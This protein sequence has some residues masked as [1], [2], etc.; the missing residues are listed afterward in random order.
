[1]KGPT[2]NHY[3]RRSQMLVDGRQRP[4]D[5]TSCILK[6]C[7]GAHSASNTLLGCMR[8]VSGGRQQHWSAPTASCNTMVPRKPWRQPEMDTILGLVTESTSVPA[9]AVGCRI[10]DPG[11]HGYRWWQTAGFS[12]SVRTVRA[13]RT[14]RPPTHATHP[15]SLSAF[16][17]R[18]EQG[19]REGP[20]PKSLCTTKKV[21]KWLQR[22]TPNWTFPLRSFLFP[23]GPGAGVALLQQPCNLCCIWVP[24]WSPIWQLSHGSITLAVWELPHHGRVN[25][26]HHCCCIS[27]LKL[28]KSQPL[29]TPAV[30]GL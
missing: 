30:W 8:G 25:G 15:F 27:S 23:G 4:L 21:R 2:A 9:G 11:T 7:T 5:D 28:E 22:Y 6:R 3:G 26:L 20:R 29:L 19:R 17:E 1:M 12:H 14:V 18:G 13:Q 10:Q 24:G 16:W